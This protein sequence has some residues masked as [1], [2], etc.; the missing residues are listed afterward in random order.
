MKRSAGIFH[1]LALALVLCVFGGAQASARSALVLTL[2]GGIGPA[3]TEYVRRG[4]EAAAERKAELVVLRM[5][6]PGGLDS[7]TRDIVRLILASPVPVAAFV[8]PSGARAAS[9]GTYI[10]YASHLAAMA[11]ATNLGAATPVRMGGGQTPGVGKEGEKKEPS[12]DAMERKVIND[13]VAWIR[14]LAQLH[15]RNA[16]WAERAVREG[17]SLTATDAA[18]LGVIE[19]LAPDTRD[20]LRQA[21]GRNVQVFGEQ[22]TL[23]TANLEIEAYDPDWRLRILSA[24]ANPNIA[25]ILL[26]AGVY[27]LLF[28]IISPG[29]MIPGALGGVFLLVGLYALNLLDVSVAGGLLILLGI[30]FMA[31][32]ALTPA[33]GIFGVAGVLAFVAGSLF[34]FREAPPEMSLS[35]WVIASATALTAGV[36][37]WAAVTGLRQWRKPVTS[38][39]AEY[40]NARGSV[41]D[42]A[43]GEGHVH[44]H[45]ETWRA[46]SVSHFAAGDNVRILRREGLTLIVEPDGATTGN[47]D[48]HAV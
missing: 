43:G 25:Y 27:G 42:W 30:A 37:A 15:G 36:F 5:N 46:R 41:L 48:L 26:I 31:A 10:L 29:A 34:L 45:G 44:F 19:L 21:D 28:E 38:G 7:A 8:A 24:I 39:E 23:A 14:G 11:P 32:E 35:P 40:A 12:G 1:A 4:L 20:L 33:F 16:D 9:A 3:T 6:T 22:R 18:K 2:D 47:G 13:S 17:A